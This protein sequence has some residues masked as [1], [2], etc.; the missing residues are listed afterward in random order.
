MEILREING[1]YVLI[2]STSSNEILI[3]DD[4]DSE[5]SLNI[6]KTLHKISKGSYV[7]LYLEWELTDKCNFRCPFCY[8]VGHSHSKIYRFNKIKPII[9]ELLKRGLLFVLLTGGEVTT[10]PDFIEIYEYL[11]TNGVLVEV[12]TNGSLLGEKIINSFKKYPPYKVEISIYGIDQESF[13]STT[14]SKEQHNT[15]LDNIL[16]LQQNGINIKCKTP[17][18]ML[19]YRNKEDIESWCK[20]NNIEFYFSTDVYDAYDGENL[21]NFNL[22]YSDKIKF[23]KEKIL[24]TFKIKENNNIKKSFLCGSGEYAFHL[25]PDLKVCPCSSMQEDYCSFSL[26]NDI[27]G[28][29]KLKN[30]ILS[31]KGQ[32]IVNCQGCFAYDLC[33]MCPAKATLYKENNQFIYMT[34][35]FH[36]E[37]I[38]TYFT[39]ITK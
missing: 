39:D 12:Y 30:F 3:A 15:I 32:E 7:P 14:Q 38:Q 4:E 33:K 25:T 26:L 37:K 5:N 2:N 21:Q 10:H 34:D 31:I 20:I 17:M 36:C 19:T 6:N 28:L 16:K 13:N 11:K 1:V 18:N 27:N 24:P 29:D 23:D 9:D 8:I 22:N 35:N